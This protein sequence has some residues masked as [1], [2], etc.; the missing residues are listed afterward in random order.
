MKEMRLAG[1]DSIATANHFLETRFLSQWEERFSVAPRNPRN[2]HRR[3]H[4]EQR[5]EEILS[6]RVG[7]RRSHR[8]LGWQPL[9]R[10]TRR[11]VRGSSGCAGGNRTTTGWLALATLPRPL[12][13]P[14]PLPST[15][16]TVRKSLRPTASRTCGTNTETQ[17]QNQTQIP[18]ASRSSWRR[19]WKRT[20]LSGEKPDISTLR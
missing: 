5:L 7:R 3:L 20:F 4:R 14:A 9:G 15:P 1:I 10:A 2:A 6:V 17:K 19:P 8:Q 16:A 11:S 12:S 18:C 13:P